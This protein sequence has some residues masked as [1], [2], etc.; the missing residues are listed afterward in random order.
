MGCVKVEKN[1]DIVLFYKVNSIFQENP[2]LFYGHGVAYSLNGEDP[3][4]IESGTL[5]RHKPFIKISNNWYVSRRLLLGGPRADMLT[6]IPKA[7]ID[8]SLKIDGIDP[9]ELHKFD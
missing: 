5:K 3:N 8:H 4:K 7:L 6:S 2:F 9:N 1:S